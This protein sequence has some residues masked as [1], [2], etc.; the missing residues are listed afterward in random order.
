MK[1][2]SDVFYHSFGVLCRDNTDDE[3]KVVV[4]RVESKLM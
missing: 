2:H 1:R 3:V 4:P